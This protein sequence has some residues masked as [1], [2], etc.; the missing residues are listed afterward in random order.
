MQSC[1]LLYLL[2]YYLFY[3]V[4]PSSDSHAISKKDESDK[5]KHTPILIQTTRP[6]L[7][8]EEEEEIE[9][10][11][12]VPINIKVSI[13]VKK[14]MRILYKT[15]LIYFLNLQNVETKNEREDSDKEKYSDEEI[16]DEIKEASDQIRI[17]DEDEDVPDDVEII[18][19]EEIDEELDEVD[20]DEEISD[21][22][23][24]EL[25]SRLEAK[26]G[27]L[28]ET[29]Q[30]EKKHSKDQHYCVSI[31]VI[32]YTITACACLLNLNILYN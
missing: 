28:T 27:R 14:K 25:L 19:D 32:N 4:A 29:Q 1:T 24:A 31:F 18:D 5:L 21:V 9:E 22:D 17:E 30:P 23:D 26:Y 2:I 16:E 8:D 13:L 12:D 20:E 7:D 15:K 10:V 6:T 3:L 11:I